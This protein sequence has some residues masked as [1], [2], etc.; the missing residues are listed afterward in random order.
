MYGY[1]IFTL[2]MGLNG[3]TYIVASPEMVSAMQRAPSTLNLD[4]IISELTPRLIDMSAHSGA[5][6]RDYTSEDGLYKQSHKILTQQAL[7]NGSE[8]QLGYLAEFVNSIENGS[9]VELFHFASKLICLASNRTFFG[10]QNPY[11]KHPE[12]LD[13][14]WEWESGVIPMLVGIFPRII[15][16][17]AYKGL[18][19][20]AEKFAEYHEA[21]GIEDAH[22]FIKQRN[23][24]HLQHGITDRIERGKLD[25]GLG[26]AVNVNASLSTFWLLSNV[27]SR[28]TL[29]ARLRDEIQENGLTDAETLSFERLREN[30]PLLYSVYRETLRCYAPMGSPRFVEADTIIANQYLVRKGSVVQPAPAAL[31]QDKDV[32]GPDAEEFNPNRFLQSANGT[33][34]NH[35]GTFED[36]SSVPGAAFRSFGGGR[37]MCPGRNFAAA[38]ILSLSAAMIIGFDMEVADNTA[39]NPPPDRKRM[40]ISVMKPL[41]KLMVTM[42]RRLGYENIQWRLQL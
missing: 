25:T 27:Y 31:H 35:D 12:L 34:T 2:P 26:I 38:E 40:P 13:R 1:P 5:V 14:F 19:A 23:E 20:C 24:L 28:P 3:R 10:P 21:G 36:K 33:K 9:K 22:Y 4:V 15:A 11:D 18:L 39:W 32:W 29:L 37:H 42:H 17:K 7:T 8:I 6:L 16:R 30:C 41:E